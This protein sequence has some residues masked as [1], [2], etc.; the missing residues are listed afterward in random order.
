MGTEKGDDG[1][2]KPGRC[3]LLKTL[4]TTLL[5]TLKPHSNISLVL[6]LT[7]A[8]HYNNRYG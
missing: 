4:L 5:Q 2:D 3:K 8:I 1:P 6:I 7:K